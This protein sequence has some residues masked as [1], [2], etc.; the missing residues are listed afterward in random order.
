MKAMIHE[1]GSSVMLNPHL[2]CYSFSLLL[3]K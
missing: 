3:S 1:Y 2:S